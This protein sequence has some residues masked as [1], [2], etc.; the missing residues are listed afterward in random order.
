MQRYLLGLTACLLSLTAG[1]GWTW[2]Q[3]SPQS[4]NASYTTPAMKSKGIIYILPGI[5]GMDDHYD[6]IR[7]GLRRAGVRSAIEI[8]LWGSQIPGVKLALNQMATDAG[9]DWGR[10]IADD[11]CEY[12]RV[13]PGRSVHLIGQSGGSAMAVFVLEAL[14]ESDA[15]SVTG[16]ILLDASLSADYDLTVALSKSTQGIVNFRNSEDVAVLGVGTAAMGNVDGGHGDSAGRTGFEAS[17][18]KLYRVKVTPNMVDGSDASHFADTSVAFTVKYIA[19]W[20]MQRRW[21]VPFADN[22]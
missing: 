14:A 19:P 7:D 6:T 17:P 15:S 21:P 18:P 2:W 3:E 4:L 16:V 22:N 20:I 8:H 11:I 12:Q 13:Y 9:R 1:C 5:Q 10:K